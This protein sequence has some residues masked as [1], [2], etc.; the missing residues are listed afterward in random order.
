M[1]DNQLNQGIILGYFV[2][3][4]IL[5]Y[6]RKSRDDTQSFI[7]AGRR[8]T[9]PT[10]VAT[11]V[12]TW[13]G[14]ILEVGRFAHTNGIVTWLIFGVFYYFAAFC[15]ATFIAPKIIENRIRSIPSLL[16]R[17]G[18]KAAGILSVILILLI[19]SPAP[20]L[21]IFAVLIQDI[22][23]LPEFCIVLAGIMISVF[24]ALRGGF[25][26]IVRT[27]KLQFVLM[28]AGFGMMLWNL[29]SNFGGYDFLIENTPP[30]LFEIP[31]NFSWTTVFVW[32]FIAMITFID[33]GFFQRSFAGMDLKTVKSGI[34][35]SILFWILFDFMTVTTGIYA[36]ALLPEVQSSPY[37]D[38]AKLVLSPL[39]QTLF[40]ISLLAIVMSTIDS[41]TFISAYTIGMDLTK[42]LN[43]KSSDKTIYSNTKAGLYI[44]A[45]IALVITLFFKNA[46]EMW[47]TVGSIAVPALMIPVISGLYNVQYKNPLLLMVLPLFITL[48]W[49]SFGILNPDE[50]GF[51]KYMLGLDPMYPGVCT[52]F[53][54]LL[55]LRYKDS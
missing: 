42:I 50:W 47:Y 14:G 41:F 33:P 43:P 13:Y 15:F 40:M 11:L 49:F 24:Y 45:G 8:L 21:K 25:S 4:Y 19:A 32:G 52:S 46:I 53:L 51:P 18:G 16:T 12:S 27:D 28:F 44:I 23:P 1:I 36:A 5:G 34:R 31:G 6:F 55:L 29:V 48:T 54:L 37:L 10:F 9:L 35:I 17:S 20:Y 38:L 7:F 30:H 3:V 39:A 22:L 26:S 2:V